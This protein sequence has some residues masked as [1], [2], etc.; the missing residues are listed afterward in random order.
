MALAGWLLVG[1][2]IVLFTIW[3]CNYLLVIGFSQ[4]M[5]E[6]HSNSKSPEAFDLPI[7]LAISLFQI[8]GFVGLAFVLF[9]FV[10]YVS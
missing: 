4:F 6:L 5:N 1:A 10:G 2:M 7:K 3:F 9:K 8:V